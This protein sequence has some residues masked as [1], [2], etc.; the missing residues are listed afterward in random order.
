MYRKDIF[1]AKGLTMPPNPTWDQVADLAGKV[2]GAQPGMKGICLRGQ[3]GWGQMG[4]P[5]TT[6]VNTFGGTWFDAGLEC[7]G[8]RS[9][10]QGRDKLLH[11]PGEG[12]R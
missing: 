12:S 10:L 11:R 7:P 4:A 2:D 5:L 9:G 1:D 8:Q 6:V 3:P